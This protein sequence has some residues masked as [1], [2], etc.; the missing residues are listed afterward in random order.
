MARSTA[1]LPEPRN[2][3]VWTHGSG[4]WVVIAGFRV[5]GLIDGNPE[6][7]HFAPGS[8]LEALIDQGETQ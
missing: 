2:Q 4:A 8:S 7:I 1:A 5:L 6:N 3:P